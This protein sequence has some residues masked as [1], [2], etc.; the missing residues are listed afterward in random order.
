LEMGERSVVRPGEPCLTLIIL[1]IQVGHRVLTAFPHSPFYS[2]YVAVLVDLLPLRRRLRLQALD[3]VQDPVPRLGA[4]VADWNKKF[5]THTKG[6]PEGG[7][8]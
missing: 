6:G 4:G 5:E 1:R 2:N 3:R 7:T 8:P